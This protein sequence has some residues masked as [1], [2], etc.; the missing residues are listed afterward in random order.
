M[1]KHRRHT[2]SVCSQR[3]M[4]ANR[5]ENLVGMEAT[6]CPSCRPQQDLLSAKGVVQY[7]Q[8]PSG[9]DRATLRCAMRFHKVGGVAIF[10][11]MGPHF[12]RGLS[13]TQRRRDRRVR[14]RKDHGEPEGPFPQCTTRL[15]RGRSR[16]NIYKL[17][18]YPRGDR[19]DAIQHPSHAGPQTGCGQILFN[20]VCISGAFRATLQLSRRRDWVP[21]HQLSIAANLQQHG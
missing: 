16:R 10:R 2:R 18:A 11:G 15:N 9:V 3:R 14:S 1:V 21:W 19:P 12:P 6:G 20:E 8:I 4:H 13:R 7:S 5:H 17:S